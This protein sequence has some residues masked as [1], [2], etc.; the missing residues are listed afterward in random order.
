MRCRP[1]RRE[2]TGRRPVFDPSAH[3]RAD[4]PDDRHGGAG[5]GA[6][7]GWQHRPEPVV[8]ARELQ[9]A[10]SPGGR[11]RAEPL[12]RQR[13]PAAGHRRP[14]KATEKIKGRNGQPFRPFFCLPIVHDQDRVDRMQYITCD[15][16]VMRL[17]LGYSPQSSGI[18]ET[19]KYAAVGTANGDRQWVCDARSGYRDPVGAEAGSQ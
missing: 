14:T 19:I 2:R 16:I 17:K 11:H 1:A 6:G 5:A 7:A 18:N 13:N 3:H 15:N 10:L 12:L 4:R 8:A 9:G